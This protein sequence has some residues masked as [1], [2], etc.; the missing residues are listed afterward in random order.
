MRS[1]VIGCSLP[2]NWSQ[3]VKAAVLHVIALA[4]VAIVHARGLAVNSHDAR[5][6]RA[7]DLQGSLDEIALLEKG[8]RIKDARMTGIDAH[9]RPH[10]RPIER[11]AILE[12]WAA[13]GW[14][15]AQTARRLLVKPTTI[16]SWLKR[17]DESSPA[18]LVQLTQVGVM[19]SVRR[20]AQNGR[21][22]SLNHRTR[23]ARIRISGGTRYA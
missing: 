11:M 1:N 16:A 5:T 2:K 17:V 19:P 3:C 15:Q 22:E 23:P 4:R 12:L 8:L 21:P 13:R 20:T 7:G 6:R 18:P 10:H 14:S 9:R